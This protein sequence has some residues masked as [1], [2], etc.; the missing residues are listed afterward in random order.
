MAFYS[1]DSGDDFYGDDYDGEYY[2]EDDDDWMEEVKELDQK[3]PKAEDSVVCEC[4]ACCDIRA[5]KYT[6]VNSISKSNN[7]LYWKQVEKDQM[8]KYTT[9]NSHLAV[10]DPLR[11]A[12]GN[13]AV[14]KR[15]RLI[16]EYKGFCVHLPNTEKPRPYLEMEE[17]S[18][19][20]GQ[21]AASAL[22]G[23]GRAY[24]DK[25]REDKKERELQFDYTRLIDDYHIY[26]DQIDTP[27]S[28]FPRHHAFTMASLSSTCSLLEK[29]LWE[30]AKTGFRIG[31]NRGSLDMG[32]LPR[33]SGVNP[34][35]YIDYR[36]NTIP[37]SAATMWLSNYYMKQAFTAAK[38]HAH[39]TNEITR[40][41]PLSQMQ[42]NMVIAHAG[43]V[44]VLISRLFLPTS[45][46]YYQYDHTYRERFN[47]ARV[48]A[49]R[50][51]SKEESEIFADNRYGKSGKY[52]TDQEFYFGSH[53]VSSHPVTPTERIEMRTLY[54]SEIGNIMERIKKY[55]RG[56]VNAE[57]IREDPKFSLLIALWLA[58]LKESMSINPGAS[59][60]HTINVLS[61][62]A[63]FPLLYSSDMLSL[64]SA[65]VARLVKATHS[66]TRRL[67]SN[68]IDA[69]SNH[70]IGCRVG[71]LAFAA[72]EPRMVDE[73]IAPKLAICGF[74]GNN[75]SDALDN[76]VPSRCPIFGK[77]RKKYE[78]HMPRTG[79]C[80]W[81]I[82]RRNGGEIRS[83]ISYQ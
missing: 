79:D 66:A 71:L 4:R 73:Y 61:V 69:N 52:E 70:P 54:E 25:I 40:F 9:R 22:A 51:H 80:V 14:N 28:A 32:L 49:R 77:L 23:L 81:E 43:I 37:V 65:K 8:E 74:D 58:C 75:C 36:S 78:V 26:F 27:Y 56:L 12:C 6:K 31:T 53:I 46:P 60:K 45:L 2:S 17:E 38:T 21:R 76:H 47:Q 16:F 50:V 1:S 72:I 82:C 18:I 48:I 13:G 11:H 68:I 10:N 19:T 3:L 39:D 34:V 42:R 83:Y 20:R 35:L 63:E 44:G 15:R 64:V 59:I 62:V 5:G 57:T 33:N 30:T 55:K 7:K 41:T 67:S 24:N 29:G